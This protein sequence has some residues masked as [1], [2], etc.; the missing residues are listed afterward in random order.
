MITKK[1]ID[2]E[3]DFQAG[4]VILIDKPKGWSS[5]KAVRKIRSAVNVKKVG[6]AGTL[7]PMATGLLIICTGKK[8]KSISEYQG[9]YKVYEGTITLGKSSPSMDTE[10]EI[11]EVKIPEGVTE[12]RILA[13]KEKFTGRIKQ[14]P[15][16][17]S[18]LKVNGKPLY[19]MARQ[20]KEIKR[21]PRE[22]E[23][24]EF[25]IKKIDLPDIF[26]RI[27]C[28]AGTYIRSIASELGDNLGC[29][30]LL[31]R[32]RRTAIGSNNVEDAFLPDEFIEI[33]STA[34]RNV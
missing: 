24:Y 19:K 34:G 29:G 27:K 1:T 31:S 18:A 23:I 28:S 10:T 4:E 32:L 3:F 13:E 33:L 6:H 11:T 14:V 25:Q 8:T 30:G 7:D 15:P 9:M 22:I 17:F 5:F 26:F 21:E 20:G 16:M 12:E 2:K